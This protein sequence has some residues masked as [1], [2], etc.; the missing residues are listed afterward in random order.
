MEVVYLAERVGGDGESCA[1]DFDIIVM[2]ARRHKS[3]V[4]V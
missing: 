2:R 1:Q 4:K 3:R